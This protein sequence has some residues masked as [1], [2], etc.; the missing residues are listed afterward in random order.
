MK[1]NKY[2]E[3]LEKAYGLTEEPRTDKVITRALLYDTLK[4]NTSTPQGWI[5]YL[6]ESLDHFY[7][8]LVI[9]P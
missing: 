4:G 8:P 6:E 3:R 5:T 9:S 2:L 7:P 1:R